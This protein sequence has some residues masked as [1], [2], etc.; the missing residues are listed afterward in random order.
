MNRR[1]IL[2]LVAVICLTACEE[3]KSPYIPDSYS[4]LPQSDFSLIAFNWHLASIPAGK[5]LATRGTLT[6]FNPYDQVSI[7]E[8]W[9]WYEITPEV[10]QRIHVLNFCFDP[11]QGISNPIASWHG[12]MLHLSQDFK[13]QLAGFQAVE[14]TIKGDQ[15]RI[16]FD[17]GEISEDVI[18]NGKLDNEDKAIMGIRNARLDPGEDIGLDGMAG[19]DPQDWWDLNNNGIRE[20]EEPISYDDY[21]YQMGSNDYRKINGSEGNGYLPDTEDLNS[22]NQLDN[23]NNYFEYSINLDKSS[24]DTVLIRPSVPTNGSGGWHTYRI[25]LGSPTAIIGNPNPWKLDFFR[26]W[27]DGMPRSGAISIAT[28]DFK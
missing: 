7:P 13:N 3:K 12:I 23:Q 2:F 24:A 22:N 25:D 4:L 20:P 19:I 11:T 8:I 1:L 28:I 10:P 14:V 16:H 18:P 21:A 26:I 15:G 5:N 9:P 27:V 17:I 6:W